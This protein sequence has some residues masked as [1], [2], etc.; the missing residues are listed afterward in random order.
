MGGTARAYLINAEPVPDALPYQ[1]LLGMVAQGEVMVAEGFPDFMR[2]DVHWI[3][4]VEFGEEFDRLAEQLDD[5]ADM[6][7]SCANCTP[8][9]TLADVIEQVTREQEQ[10]AEPDHGVDERDYQLEAQ[11]PLLV[12]WCLAAACT[13]GIIWTMVR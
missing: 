4:P 10:V 8:A 7:C 6:P 11:L 3:E 13:A 5:L 9:P 2:A 1:A 12:V